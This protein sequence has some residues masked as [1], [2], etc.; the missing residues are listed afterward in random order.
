M[1]LF[2]SIGLFD[3]RKRVTKRRMSDR[4][5]RVYDKISK[6]RKTWWHFKTRWDPNP[7]EILEE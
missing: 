1:I 2:S 7:E 5:R 4:N 6:Y 3:G